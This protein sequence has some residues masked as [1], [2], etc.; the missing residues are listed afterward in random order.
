MEQVRCTG[1]MHISSECRW[2]REFV[3]KTAREWYHVAV[4]SPPASFEKVLFSTFIL[5][6]L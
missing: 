3:Q 5:K 4:D 1:R 6:F 2:R